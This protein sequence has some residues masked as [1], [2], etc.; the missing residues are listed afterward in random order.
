MEPDSALDISLV[1]C[2]DTRQCSS[3][4]RLKQNEAFRD[5]VVAG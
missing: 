5:L 3:H 4:A 2:K 1:L